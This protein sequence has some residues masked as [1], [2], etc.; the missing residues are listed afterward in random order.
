[1]MYKSTEQSCVCESCFVVL[2]VYL[3]L[4]GPWW[5]HVQ[6][7]F[8]SLYTYSV[9]FIMWEGCHVRLKNLRACNL[10][11]ARIHALPAHQKPFVA[12]RL[13]IVHA[14]PYG[15]PQSHT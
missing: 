15:A 14:H 8:L 10:G 4:P 13:S 11:H 3:N 1:M 5:D 12:A 6:H 7:V 9:Y 2:W